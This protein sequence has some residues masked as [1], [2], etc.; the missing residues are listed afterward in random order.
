MSNFVIEEFNND[1]LENLIMSICLKEC[2]SIK[3]LINLLIDF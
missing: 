2:Q 1:L 3:F